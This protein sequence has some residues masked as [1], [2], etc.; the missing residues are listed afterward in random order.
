MFSQHFTWVNKRE[1]GVL[2]R[3]SLVYVWIANL[4]VKARAPDAEWGAS[5]RNHSQNVHRSIQFNYHIH[6]EKKFS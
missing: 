6:I 3:Y 2:F 4:A 1:S 5:R